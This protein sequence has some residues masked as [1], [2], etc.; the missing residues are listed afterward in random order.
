[1]RKLKATFVEDHAVRMF[2]TRSSSSRPSIQEL[3]GEQPADIKLSRTI[4]RETYR[5]GKKVADLQAIDENF[6]TRYELV[7]G[8]ASVDN[9]KFKIVGDDLIAKEPI[10][11]DI[12]TDYF[13]RV[14]S[15]DAR[16]VS[17]EEALRFAV[18]QPSG[19]DL[20]R[21]DTE[22]DQ[23]PGLDAQEQSS[24][25]DQILRAAYDKTSVNFINNTASGAFWV[26]SRD[27]RFE[28]FVLNPGMS[29]RITDSITGK[30]N[31]DVNSNIRVIGLKPGEHSSY[32][33]NMRFNNEIAGGPFALSY[34]A[35]ASDGKSLLLSNTGRQANRNPPFYYNY[36][37][38]WD[39]AVLQSSDDNVWRTMREGVEIN[40]V[41][42]NLTSV[43]AYGEALFE[44]NVEFRH[45][46]FGSVNGEKRWDFVATELPPLA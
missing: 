11:Y 22:L 13:V 44:D 4:V 41:D 12:Q 32:V 5:G 27:N 37:N 19:R 26:Q 23:L 14:R 15:T 17:R 28:G 43:N 38:S 34:P 8:I 39:K 2:K 42:T 45:Y 40:F 46:Y 25:N 10:N 36:D 31:F 18:K 1:M 33:G 24:S 6:T 16:G 35:I 30:G 9:E 20:I 3:P 7:G 29:R 21:G